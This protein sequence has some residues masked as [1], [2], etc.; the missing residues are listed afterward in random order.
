MGV[1][2]TEL[3]LETHGKT[4]RELETEWRETMGRDAKTT[5]REREMQRL[6]HRDMQEDGETRTEMQRWQRRTD[7]QR[8]WAMKWGDGCRDREKET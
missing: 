2:W 6:G 8:R 4:E 7:M 3:A 5:E 1:P